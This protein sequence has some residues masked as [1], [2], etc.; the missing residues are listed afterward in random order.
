MG[1]LTHAKDEV[2][3][4]LAER[5][6]MNPVGTPINETLIAI[7]HHLY[8]ESEAKLG[9]KFPLFP[10]TL[11]LIASKVGID[12][13]PLKTMLNSMADKG[14]V[15]DIPRKDTVYYML[16][17]MVVGFFEY[18]FMRARDNVNMK[19]LAELFQNYFHAQGVRDEFSGIETRIM[20]TLVYESILPVAVET[21]ILTYE[22][23]SEII[24]QSGGGAISICP[25]RHKAH[26][27]GKSCG[28]PLEVCTSLGMAADWVIR[29]DMGKPATVDELLRVLDQTEKLGLVHNCD[30]VMNKPAYI[31][32]C[33]GCCCVILTGIREFGK[34]GTHPSNFIPEVSS[35]TCV[36]CGT[37]ADK[38]HIK[39]INMQDNG[40]GGEIPVVA[41]DICIGCGVCASA[42]P[43]DSLTMSH[44]SKLHV[45]PNNAKDKFLRIAKE[46]GKI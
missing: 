28:A 1:H 39:A 45:P 46:K 38:C 25:C 4:L 30:N 8:T 7:L 37:C 17:P 32:H 15:M 41:K 31:C 43:T 9:S 33:C 23:A 13:E 16:T 27:L 24:R 2:Y 10:M 5:L 22:K 14:L 18:T 40:D 44:R 29:R 34:F 12:P 20:R 6:N 19:D 21:E 3:R 11:E 42:C 26:H 35:D 36:G